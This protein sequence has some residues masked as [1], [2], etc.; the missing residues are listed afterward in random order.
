[1]NRRNI[2]LGVLAFLFL[3]S[4][5]KL[6][7]LENIRREVKIFSTFEHFVQYKPLKVYKRESDYLSD[8]SVKSRDNFI[9]IIEEKTE[10]GRI[11]HTDFF[12]PPGSYEKFIRLNEYGFKQTATTKKMVATYDTLKNLFRTKALKTYKSPSCE[13]DSYNDTI[14]IFKNIP[15]LI[16]V[17]YFFNQQ[18]GHIYQTI[19]RIPK[20]I[21][22]EYLQKMADAGATIPKPSEVVKQQD[23]K[24][25]TLKF[26]Y[27]NKYVDNSRELALEKKY[28][29]Q[30]LKT[31]NI[32]MT[33]TY[34]EQKKSYYLHRD[35][36]GSTI[37]VTDQEGKL[38]ERVS[39]GIY[40]YQT[41]WDYSQDPNVP[42]KRS[43]SVIGNVILF[44]GR[45]YDYETGLYY[46]RNRYYDPQMGRFLQTDPMAYND[47]MNLYEAFNNNP[48]NF[49][50]PF[51]LT[52]VIIA[53]FRAVGGP[54]AA[55]NTGA[56]YERT[57]TKTGNF[58]IGT[59]PFFY[60]NPYSRYSYSRIPWNT[61][62]R[63]NKNQ[64][65]EFKIDGKWKTLGITKKEV[66]GAMLDLLKEVRR[67][68]K[69]L[70][71]K[72]PQVLDFP[73]TWVLN[74]YGHATVAY[75]DDKN[76]NGVMDS[77][78]ILQN[79]M[80]HPTPLGELQE[81]LGI[82]N[83]QIFLEGSHGCIHLTPDDVDIMISKGYLRKGS[84]II[85]HSYNEDIPKQWKFEKNGRGPYEI[86][87]FPGKKK[88]FILGEK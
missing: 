28:N 26:D 59:N 60:S 38:I 88:M 4:L 53:A 39:Y 5:S 66:E 27:E 49:I 40:G 31:K 3:I 46:F 34:P 30:N 6:F 42:I 57:P 48:I 83:N 32:P 76:K 10:D 33:S 15:N 67:K 19:Y 22:D 72:I 77:G 84:K 69:S 7:P 70:N 54:N 74:D 44:Q 79:D 68:H 71:N 47:S 21:L 29:N 55:S 17:T 2:F 36:Q 50:D 37:A 9:K 87:F 16:R 11:I 80:I 58:I 81:A 24:Y 13:S 25:I 43:R 62:M 12:I 8:N 18:S 65:V 45:R 61:P 23:E 85:I 1:M 86:H 75:F 63:V 73:K 20:I 64:L 52:K 82:P 51:G 78:E 14:H 35:A 56:Q 41:F